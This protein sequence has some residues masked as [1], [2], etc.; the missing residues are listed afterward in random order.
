MRHTYGIE[1]IARVYPKYYKHALA[2]T[3]IVLRDSFIFILSSGVPYLKFNLDSFYS[4]YFEDIV[5]ADSHHIV[6]DELTLTVS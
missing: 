1:G 6:V 5:D 3:V 2:V 4:D